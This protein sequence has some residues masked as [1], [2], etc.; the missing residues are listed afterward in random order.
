MYL[1]GV[2]GGAH[3][4]TRPSGHR[5]CRTV[6]NSDYYL[7]PRE[8]YVAS[9]PRQVTQI[10]IDEKDRPRPWVSTALSKGEGGG[11]ASA[12]K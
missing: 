3:A 12:E 11:G 10:C 8:D 6:I 1:K 2:C 9:M 4:V 7:D 5:D